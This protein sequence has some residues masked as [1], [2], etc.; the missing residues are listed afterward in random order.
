MYHF[1]ESGL[2]NVWL[3]NGY[4][5]HETAYGPGV[6]FKDIDGLHKAIAR[7]LIDKP[8]RLTGKEF[9]YLRGYLEMSQTIMGKA[10]G[11][12]E[13]SVSLWERTGKVP[14]ASD[15]LLR[16]L[17]AGKLDPN[18][19]VGSIIERVNAQERQSRQLRLVASSKPRKGWV[20]AA[21]RPEVAMKAA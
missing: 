4:T 7:T 12:T 8:G 16:F 20:M 17:V 6:S 11:V 15:A 13:Q 1:T 2:D 14:Q 5:E 3:E 9:R 21:A 19:P 18:T 10:L